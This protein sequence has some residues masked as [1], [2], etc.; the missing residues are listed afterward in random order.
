MKLRDY[1]LYTASVFRLGV[2]DTHTDQGQMGT[3]FVLEFGSGY[4]KMYAYT[5]IYCQRWQQ[6]HRIHADPTRR[7]YKDKDLPD[8]HSCKRKFCDLPSE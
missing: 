6:I 5:Y 2:I 1:G 3:A 7:W 4:D 8:Y